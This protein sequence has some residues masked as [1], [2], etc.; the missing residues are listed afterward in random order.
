MTE[1]GPGT[2]RRPLRALFVNEA[3]GGHRTVHAALRTHLAGR[4]D[5]A[6]EFF[7]APDPRV[8]GRVAGA[9]IP[10]LIRM[11]ADYQPLRAQLVRS[12]SVHRWLRRRLRQGDVDVVH[13]YTQNCV[14]LSADLLRGIPTVVSTD[15]TTAA[16]AY[17]LPYRRP[18]LGTPATVRASVPFERRV[19]AAADR[20]VATSGWT[21]DMIRATGAVDADRLVV[22][23]FGVSLPPRP[24]ERPRRRPTIAFVGH[25]M[26]R[27]GGNQLLR[28]H[29]QHLRDVCDLVLVTTEDVAPAP[30]VRIVRDLRS[31]DGRL[32]DVLADAD[33]FCFPSTM[34]QAP[35]AVLEAAAAGLPVVAHPVAAVP[36][37]VV[38][39]VTGLLVPPA[40]DDALLS[41]LRSLLHDP[42]RRREM[43]RRARQHVETR[44]DMRRTVDALVGVLDE[45][46]SGPG[47]RSLR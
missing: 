31:G 34:D 7:D 39:G 42:G 44:Y 5:V 1:P 19:F 40:D 47:P 20:V 30:G 9:P 14:L 28:L 46:S 4:A 26:E 29:Q 12:R 38:D 43:G 2:T 16:N 37:M 17:R 6:A 35:N 8:L 25:S 36:E 13:V 18:G 21:A 15:S 24:R 23:P 3:I 10:G 41:A 33:L 11:D 45:V 27:K 22:L 32:W